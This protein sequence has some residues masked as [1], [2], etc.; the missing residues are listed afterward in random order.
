[1]VGQ[2]PLLKAYLTKNLVGADGLK[3]DLR[4]KKGK[5]LRGP[6]NYPM[7]YSVKDCQAC[8]VHAID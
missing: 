6:E 5:N 2:L 8:E 4:F 3:K 1:M 7:Q